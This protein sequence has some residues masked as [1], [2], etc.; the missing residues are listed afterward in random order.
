MKFKQIFK[1]IWFYF[2]LANAIAFISL[3]IVGSLT[4]DWTYI[5]GFMLYLPFGCLSSYLMYSA[6]KKKINKTNLLIVW[7]VRYFLKCVPIILC[8]ILYSVDISEINI[9]GILIG[10]I[11]SLLES[12]VFGYLKYMRVDDSKTC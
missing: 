6:A 11:I 9:I 7:V 8:T 12:I 4:N 5:Y 3:I 2:V 1:N 10:V